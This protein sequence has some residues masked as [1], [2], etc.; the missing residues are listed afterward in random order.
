MAIPR[1][2]SVAQATR[3]GSKERAS[4]AFVTCAGS[5]THS[6]APDDLSWTNGDHEKVPAIHTA[7]KRGR[8]NTDQG[9]QDQ[10]QYDELQREAQARTALS[11]AHKFCS[12]LCITVP[13]PQCRSNALTKR[14]P[15]VR[16]HWS[17]AQHDLNGVQTPRRPV[18]KNGFSR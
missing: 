16:Q 2:S 14:K 7:V 8:W 4:R 15:L 5:Q 18:C 9:A 12:K 11:I 13:L 17:F 3:S 6:G 10:E 1:S